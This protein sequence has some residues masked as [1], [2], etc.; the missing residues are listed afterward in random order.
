VPDD[1]E[2]LFTSSGNNGMIIVP[3]K[4]TQESADVNGATVNSPSRLKDF[5]QDAHTSKLN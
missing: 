1:I 4:T 2:H 5:S 3:T